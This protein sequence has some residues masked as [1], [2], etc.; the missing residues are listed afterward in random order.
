[1]VSEG[2]FAVV[3]VADI[4]EIVQCL[5]LKRDRSAFQN[6]SESR[7]VS[8]G[9]KR[10]TGTCYGD[11]WQD[12]QYIKKS[13]LFWMKASRCFHVFGNQLVYTKRT[14][15]QSIYSRVRLHVSTRG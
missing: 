6:I 3:D 10:R 7:S 5:R 8:S 1:L 11:L 4:P 15:A 13:R 9:G 14:P 12:G 2:L